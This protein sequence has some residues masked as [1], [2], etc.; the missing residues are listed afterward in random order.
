MQADG[1]QSV[2]VIGAGIIGLSV[3]LRIQQDG[4]RVIVVDRAPAMQSC[5]AGNAGHL[6]ESNIFPPASMNFY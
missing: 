4:H 2:A 3:A 1:R 5:S 6:A